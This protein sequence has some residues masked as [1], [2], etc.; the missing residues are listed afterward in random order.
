MYRLQPA[1]RPPWQMI[2]PLPPSLGISTS[3][4]M[5]CDLFLTLMKVFSI[6][7]VIPSYTRQLLAPAHQVGPARDLRIQALD[8]PVVQRQDVVLL[9]FHE[10]Q[11]LKLLELGGVLCG[12][13]VEPG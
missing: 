10:E 3:A 7:P 1:K 13:I 9:G 2:T 11:L 4:V 6:M 12:Q 5:V 8:T